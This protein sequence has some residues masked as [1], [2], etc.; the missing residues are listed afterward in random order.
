MI[1]WVSI[2][3]H[4]RRRFSNYV[5]ARAAPIRIKRRRSPDTPTIPSSSSTAH[6]LQDD[7]IQCNCCCTHV[8]N[9]LHLMSAEMQFRL[10]PMSD[11]QLNE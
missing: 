10:A 5:G 11:Q 2:V 6:S 8:S 3:R 7:R 1:D 4:S 9:I